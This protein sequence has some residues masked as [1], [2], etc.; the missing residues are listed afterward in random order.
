MPSPSSLTSTATPSAGARATA[1]ARARRRRPSPAPSVTVPSPWRTAFSSRLPRTWST[2]SG[3]AQTSGSASATRDT[4]A[5]AVV[6]A[7]DHPVDV[8][9]GDRGEVDRL[10]ADLEPAG[11]D[12]RDVE[13]LADQ[14]GHPVGVGLDGLE[15]EP[16]LVVGEPVPAAQ[17]RG[18]EALDRGQRRAQLV[19]D[20]GDQ[21]GVV[22]LGAAAVSRRRAAPSRTR[23][24]G[25]AAAR[26]RYRG[27]E[28][29]A[30]VPAAAAA[31]RGGRSGLPGRS[32]G[33]WSATRSCRRCPAAAA[34]RGRPA[35]AGR[36]A[37]QST[38]RS[39]ARVENRIVASP[40]AAMSPSGDR[41]PPAASPADSGSIT[42]RRAV[43]SMA[44][45]LSGRAG[46]SRRGVEA[47]RGGHGQV[48]AFG[49]PVDRHPH[50][51]VAARAAPS[52]SPR[53]R[54]RRPRRW[55]SGTRSASAS[56]GSVARPPRR[57]R[58]PR[59]P[60]ARSAS[61]ASPRAAQPGHD[62]QV[63]Q[64]MPAVDRTHLGCGRRRWRR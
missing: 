8:P 57:R 34:P 51:L 10:A 29:L 5:L 6:A 33:R 16:L 60:G 38:I 52:G 46:A 17:Q 56:A 61:P 64:A 23:S 24:T 21:R 36:G 49:L 31:A 25:C 58:A 7:G 50:H 55:S 62:R 15:H 42:M 3:S 9:A 41:A 37:A 26:R 19:G 47:D 40:S 45:T 28:Q 43:K 12:P 63:E 2:R 22:D 20:G 4:N 54:C 13:Q 35:R 32:T 27:D 30:A 48:E 14:P 44:P 11:V 39:A 59:S 1:T 18:R 53:P